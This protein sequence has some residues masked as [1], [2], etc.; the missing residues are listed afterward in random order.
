MLKIEK[1]EDLQEKIDNIFVEQAKE[2]DIDSNYK[3]FKFAVKDDNGNILGGITGHRLFKEIYVSNLSIDKSC[4]GQGVG[5]KLLEIVEKELSNDM[6]DYITL[7]TNKF[8]KAVE[9]Y[10]KCGFEIEFVRVNKDDRFTK[11]YMVKKLR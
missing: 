6:T 4:R 3:D 9:F 7:T 8:Q 5:K 2:H 1:V 10:K 11:Y